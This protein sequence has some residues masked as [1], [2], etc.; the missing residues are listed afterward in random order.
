M[1]KI[2]PFLWYRDKAQE[3][4]RFYIS[5]FK[6]SRLVSEQPTI[7]EIEGQQFY[8]FNGGPHFQLTPAISLFVSVALIAV[9]AATPP[10][11]TSAFAFRPRC[12]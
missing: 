8:A 6:N 1:E 3:A 9:L 5:I 7:F 12:R 2:V 11:N 10:A 4:A